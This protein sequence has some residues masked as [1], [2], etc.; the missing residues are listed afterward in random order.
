MLFDLVFK[1]AHINSKGRGGG[2]TQAKPPVSYSSL[3]LVLLLP[4][5]SITSDQP[6]LRNTKGKML[7]SAHHSQES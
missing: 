7:S 5:D 4:V 3:P 1:L 2:V 6:R